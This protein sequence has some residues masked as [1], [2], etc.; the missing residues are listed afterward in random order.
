M[1]PK[2]LPSKRRAGVVSISGVFLANTHTQGLCKDQSLS[3]RSLNTRNPEGA[4]LPLEALEKN[5][6]LPDHDGSGVP[7]WVWRWLPELGLTQ[8]ASP[9]DSSFDLA[10]NSL[11]QIRY[12]LP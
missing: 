4:P 3:L 12:G 2:A 8:P 10:A 5:F 6:A 9:S 11:F 1:K 7:W